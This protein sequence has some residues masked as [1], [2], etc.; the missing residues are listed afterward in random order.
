M[1][2]PTDHAAVPMIPPNSSALRE[3]CRAIGDA[4][5]LPTPATE[6]DELTYLR[7]SRDRARLV[8]FAC[9]RILADREADDRDIMAAVSSI[10]EESRQLPADQYAAHPMTW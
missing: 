5:T 6:K 1:S 3:F 7:I 2:N 4:L 9:K 8:M 10:R